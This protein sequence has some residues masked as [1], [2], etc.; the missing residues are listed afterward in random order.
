M[1]RP[2]IFAFTGN[3]N[4]SKG[5]REIFE[6]LPHHYV[7][8]DDLPT[9]NKDIIDGK[10][11]KHLLY[12][13][14]VDVKDMVRLKDDSSG[15]FD[16]AHYYANPSLYEGCFHEKVKSIYNYNFQIIAMFSPI[17]A[18]TT[19]TISIVSEGATLYQRPS[20]RHVLGPEISSTRHEAADTT[21]PERAR[22]LQL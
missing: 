12:A 6:Q 13:I 4:V 3:G 17:T 19:T 7:T 9:L 10:R 5:I 11:S 14:N 20:Q 15:S 18:S 22:K 8:I 2:L 16:K 21:S 1:Q